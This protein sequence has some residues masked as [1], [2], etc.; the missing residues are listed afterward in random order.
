VLFR[1]RLEVPAGGEEKSGNIGDRGKSDG[2]EVGD[3]E[4]VGDLR[5]LRLLL[6]FDVVFR[7]IL[8]EL[9]GGG[10]GERALED[11]CDGGDG[12]R[13]AT[14]HMGDLDRRRLFCGSL[15]VPLSLL[16]MDD[17][18]DENQISS[19]ERTGDLGRWPLLFND[20]DA[21]VLATGFAGVVEEMS[22]TTTGEGRMLLKLRVVKL[23]G[24][25]LSGGDG[26]KTGDSRR[27]GSSS[28][29]NSESKSS[30]VSAEDDGALAKRNG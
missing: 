6:L 29:S 3:L 15:D 22:T 18:E 27:G 11:E 30:A 13:V 23:L 16:T 19:T 28:V 5:F 4:R 12:E 2:N 21:T 1:S 26:F 9:D 20:L 7:V 17:V 24:F 8:L 14:G 10:D 25:V